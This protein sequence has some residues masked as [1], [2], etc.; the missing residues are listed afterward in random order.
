MKYDHYLIISKTHRDVI[1]RSQLQLFRKILHGVPFSSA[2]EIGPGFGGFA[3]YCA[4]RGIHY[5]AIEE[6][7]TIAENLRT[8]GHMVHLSDVRS[9]NAQLGPV[10]LVFASHVIEHLGSYW[11]AATVLRKSLGWL[12][13][14]GYMALLFPEVELSWRQFCRDYTHTFPTTVRSV[15]KLAH[16]TGADVVRSSHYVGRWVSTWR[17][18]W[19]T[20]YMLPTALLPWSLVE[21]IDDLFMVNG[22]C[23][24]RKST[25]SA[26]TC[27]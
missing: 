6:N 13:P 9:F 12:H 10:D 2:I 24:L 16:D 7:P 1:I 23:V 25:R 17:L 26:G 11:E 8:A 19:W 18:L 22:F 21:K 15:S 4:D 14:G 27:G 3:R 5:S 20:R